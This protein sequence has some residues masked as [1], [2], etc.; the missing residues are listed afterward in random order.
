MELFTNIPT[1]PLAELHIRDSNAPPWY[2]GTP[3]SKY[4]SG[5][6]SAARQAAIIVA[7]LLRHG[8]D[9]YSPIVHSHSVAVHGKI[10]PM[11]FE[12]W[13]K[14]NNRMIHAAWGF[15]IAKLPGWQDSEGIKM[16]VKQFLEIQKPIGFLDIE[17]ENP[18]PMGMDWA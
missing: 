17:F 15:L 4:P 7:D 18:M 6:E 5:H 2:L 12:L 9:A 14:Y 16:E 8:I 11:N 13:H 3:Y 1:F 10:N